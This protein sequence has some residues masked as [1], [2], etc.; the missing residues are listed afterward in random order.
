M[1]SVGAL[2]ATEE[3]KQSNTKYRQKVFMPLHRSR[4]SHLSN[5]QHLTP[6]NYY[7]ELKGGNVGTSVV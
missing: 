4:T 1:L 7:E 2:A 5:G 6:S 3:W